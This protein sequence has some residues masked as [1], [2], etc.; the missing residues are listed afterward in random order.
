MHLQQHH[1][2]KKRNIFCGGGSDICK[3][4]CVIVES[5]GGYRGA[6]LQSKPYTPPPALKEILLAESSLLKFKPCSTE[7][8]NHAV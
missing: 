2:F 8:F 5:S 6:R 7:Q 1:R 3:Y 4:K